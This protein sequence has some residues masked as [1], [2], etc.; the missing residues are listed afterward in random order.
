MEATI[1]KRFKKRESDIESYNRLSITSADQHYYSSPTF[2]I[3]SSIL[4]SFHLVDLTA[5][6][7]AV[8]SLQPSIKF[9]KEEI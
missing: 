6:L 1:E 5:G 9:P 7:A 2:Q 8:L 4:H 3:L